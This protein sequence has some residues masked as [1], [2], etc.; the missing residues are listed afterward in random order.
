MPRCESV[1]M[2]AVASVIGVQVAICLGYTWACTDLDFMPGIFVQ[3]TR[4]NSWKWSL[5]PRFLPGH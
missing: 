4:K 3:I 5:I 2:V 1:F